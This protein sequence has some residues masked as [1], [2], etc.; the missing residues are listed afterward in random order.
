MSEQVQPAQ[1]GA[2]KKP[3]ASKT[4][5]SEKS[6]A[7]SPA[8]L[9]AGKEIFLTGSSMVWSADTIALSLIPDDSGV[10]RPRATVPKDL[11]PL[12]YDQIFRA[13][14]TGV[15]ALSDDYSDKDINKLTAAKVEDVND[16]AIIEDLALY[17]QLLSMELASLEKELEAQRK[18]YKRPKEFFESLLKEEKFSKKRQSYVDLIEKFV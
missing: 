1:E 5:S 10:N 17:D 9:L 16:P 11:S 15:I 18:E 4:K 12:V 14:K 6:A 13:I 3:T 7:E 8:K 2:E